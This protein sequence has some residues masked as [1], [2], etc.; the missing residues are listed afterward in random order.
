M[1]MTVHE[2]QRLQTRVDFHLR[3]RE[4]PYETWLAEAGEAPQ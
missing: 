2:S 1:I 4:N 3:N